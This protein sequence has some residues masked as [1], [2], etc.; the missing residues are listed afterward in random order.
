MSNFFISPHALTFAITDIVERCIS[1]ELRYRQELLA[2]YQPEAV[3]VQPNVFLTLG[4]VTVN[5]LTRQTYIDNI[6]RIGPHT[7]IA[8]GCIIGRH[9]LIGSRVVLGEG[10]ELGDAVRIEHGVKVGDLCEIE[11][12]A[13]LL[14]GSEIGSNCIIGRSVE[15]GYDHTLPI[16]TTVKP[17]KI[18]T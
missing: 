5:D 18:I 16:D 4:S 10:C 3:P 2:A 13:T 1:P 12:G 8:A 15:I 7:S 11:T 9:S 14:T 17:E 6:E